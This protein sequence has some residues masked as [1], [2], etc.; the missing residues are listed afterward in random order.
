M[1]LPQHAYLSQNFNLEELNDLRCHLGALLGVSN[2]ARIIVNRKNFV[3]F[4]HN[5]LWSVALKCWHSNL[6]EYW[7]LEAFLGSGS[8]EWVVL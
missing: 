8:E 4:C 7:I 5:L 3:N 6:I 2:S 1:F